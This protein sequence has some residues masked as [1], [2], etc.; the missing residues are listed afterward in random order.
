MTSIIVKILHVEDDRSL[1]KLVRVSLER[2]GSY[3]VRTAADGFQ[4]VDLAREFRPDLLLLDMDLPGR[5]GIATLAA[6]RDVDGMREVPAV[7]L[8][9][10]AD[11][12]SRG[13]L[14]SV[15]ARE[16]VAKPFRP[17]ELLGVIQRVLKAPKI[18]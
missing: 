16:V 8:T 15:G 14:M 18:V 11:A 13:R 7:F 5:D 4:A 1:Q 6:L 17:R 3:I 9:A 12:N 2:L 10:A